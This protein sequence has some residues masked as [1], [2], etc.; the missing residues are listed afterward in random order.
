MSVSKKSNL[1]YMSVR[2]FE[3]DIIYRQTSS[4]IYQFDSEPG[5]LG[6]NTF[7]FSSNTFRYCAYLSCEIYLLKSD[8]TVHFFIDLSFFVHHISKNTH[9]QFL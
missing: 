4:D 2:M 5:F 1:I 3:Y 8:I 7:T 6:H 9:E